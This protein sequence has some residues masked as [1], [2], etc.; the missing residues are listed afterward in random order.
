MKEILKKIISRNPGGVFLCRQRF[1]EMIVS[2]GIL[3]IRQGCIHICIH[4]ARRQRIDVNA[5]TEQIF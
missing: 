2:I 3:R 4:V 5:I 1:Q